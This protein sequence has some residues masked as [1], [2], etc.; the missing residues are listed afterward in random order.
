MFRWQYTI[1]LLVMAG[2][3]LGACALFFGVR[4][5]YQYY[6]NQRLKGRFKKISL[7]RISAILT[8]FVVLAAAALGGLIGAEIWKNRC[9][10]LYAT[11]GYY[12]AQSAQY[13]PDLSAPAKTAGQFQ[14]DSGGLEGVYENFG[15]VNTDITFANYDEITGMLAR[16]DNAYSPGEFSVFGLRD[17]ALFAFENIKVFGRWV[18]LKDKRFP[19]HAY[20]ADTECFLSYS[21][22]TGRLSFMRK[23]AL[24]PYVWDRAAGAARKIAQDLIFKL[25]FYTEGG[26]EIFECE[27]FSTLRDGNKDYPRQYQY[28]KNVKDKSFT[29]YTISP[30]TVVANASGGAEAVFEIE[31][32]N[33]YG[34][35]RRF[36]QVDYSDS[37]VE[38]LFVNQVFTSAYGEMPP[39]TSVQAYAG[40][41]TELMLYNTLFSAD[42]GFYEGFVHDPAP[43]VFYNGVSADLLKMY[44]EQDLSRIRSFGDAQKFNAAYRD[45]GDEISGAVKEVILKNKNGITVFNDFDETPKIFGRSAEHELEASYHHVLRGFQS[46]AK[47]TGLARPIGISAP[48]SLAK[49]DCAFENGLQGALASIAQNAVDSSYLKAQYGG[50][51]K[52]AKGYILV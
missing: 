3:L 13:V 45:A 42:L 6:I 26:V 9:D 35:E 5:L 11:I 34:T 25:D 33:P 52:A 19:G 15:S 27:I 4:L 46:L 43:A 30:L 50:L 44:A 8:V 17:E 28:V 41:A 22:K 48:P 10:R 31:S 7:P 32:D 2:V 37:S 36:A 23:S 47:S 24:E 1:L 14:S 39:V 20:N 49:A 18:K 16:L 12:R 40:S 38:M 51:K 29:K 21:E